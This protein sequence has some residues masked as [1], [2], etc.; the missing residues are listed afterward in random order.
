MNTVKSVSATG[1]LDWWARHVNWTNNQFFLSSTVNKRDANELVI[2]GVWCR[3]MSGSRG[4]NFVWGDCVACCPIYVHRRFGRKC[5]LHLYGSKMILQKVDSIYI[6]IYIIYDY[7]ALH[8]RIFIASGSALE[9]FK[10]KKGQV[11][12]HK[13]T[14]PTSS[15][16]IIIII[17]YSKTWL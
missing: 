12:I 13:F 4:G 17:Y 2:N 1:W 8:P 15:G 9:I 11:C 16:V 5:C 14:S 7:R 6:Y 3:D 10:L